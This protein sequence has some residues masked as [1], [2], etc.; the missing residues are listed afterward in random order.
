MAEW[1]PSDQS[2]LFPHVVTLVP[3]EHNDKARRK[4]PLKTPE[5]DQASWDS[6]IDP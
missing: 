3:I 6:I 5:N 4:N 1:L 2:P